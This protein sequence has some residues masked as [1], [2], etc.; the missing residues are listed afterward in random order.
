[1]TYKI[2]NRLFPENLRRLLLEV[3]QNL[4]G[5][6]L[7]PRRGFKDTWVKTF[8]KPTHSL[9]GLVGTERK[10]PFFQ[11]GSLERL[12]GKTQTFIQFLSKTG[13]NQSCFYSKQIGLA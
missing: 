2:L 6:P 12:P 7:A 10:N 4:Y 13:L 5:F 11:A 3:D 1:M 9:R 8:F